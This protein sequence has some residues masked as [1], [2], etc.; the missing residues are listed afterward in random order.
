MLRTLSGQ[1]LIF[2]GTRLPFCEAQKTFLKPET[3]VYFSGI[4]S[5]A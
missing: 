4:R 1:P 5:A 3:T 2:P